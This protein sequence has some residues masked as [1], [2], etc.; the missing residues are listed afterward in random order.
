MRGA[1]DSPQEPA[2]NDKKRKNILTGYQAAINLWMYQGEQV[3]ARF[4]IMLVANSI[5]VA[6]I[7]LAITSQDPLP[8]FT[9]FLP[10]VGIILCVF[11]FLLIKRESEYADYYI[12]SARELEEQYLAPIKTVSR[13]G[14]FG[15]GRKVILKIHGKEKPFQMSCWA[16]LCKAKTISNFVILIF[17]LLYATIIS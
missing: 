8:I 17:I 10:I 7:A 2:E 14:S 13:G 9:E 5:V 4:N 12:N 6:A 1:Q 16:R 11:W 3:W 15:N